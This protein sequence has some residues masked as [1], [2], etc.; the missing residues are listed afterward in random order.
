[1]IKNTQKKIKE[2]V[3]SRYIERVFPSK[4]TLLKALKKGEKLKFY[5]GIDPTGPKLHLGHSTNFFLLKKIQELGHQV[6]FLIGDFTARIG[7][8]T[9][10]SNTRKDLTKEEILENWKDYRSQVVKILN[11]NNEKSP[12]RIEF[13]NKWYKKIKLEEVIK[14]M[15]KITYGQLIKRDMFQERIKEEKEIYFHEL[16]Y[17][18]L[19]GYDSVVLEVDGEIGGTDQ[20]F[21]M[22]VGRD[23]VKEYQNRE[24]FVITTKL[25]INPKT[26]R[27]LMSKS[28]GGFI[29]LNDLPN[30]MYG[31]VMALPDE[32]IV[33]CF[34]LCTEISGQEI[35]KIKKQSK[36][37]PRDAKARLARE[38]V[39]LY[40]GEKESQKAE[41][42]FNK[43]FREKKLPSEIPV[44][45]TS[46]KSYPILDLLADSGLT[47][48]KNQAKR[49][50]E[51]GGVKIK[52]TKKVNFKKIKD[53]KK[54]LKL[55]DGEIIKVG[56]RRFRKIKLK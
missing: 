32:V 24:K 54:E 36:S 18:L 44:F 19:Q 45:E 31:K 9:G 33:P 10:K 15:G 14:L 29:A 16:F 48:S 26:K 56:K 38:I 55:K 2:V 21:N 25:L 35:E 28:K 1:M 3:E 39:K 46:K 37:N 40:H 8:P 27:K 47:S 12:I 34:E 5:I 53:W 17:P 30:E 50:I 6:I 20:T 23:L 42:E 22:L 43:V 49:L 13:N 7:D 52:K 41:E 4:K 51:G 11:F